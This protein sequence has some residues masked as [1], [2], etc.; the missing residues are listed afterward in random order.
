VVKVHS[1]QRVCNLFIFL[2]FIRNS[3]EK[4]WQEEAMNLD[5]LFFVL[6]LTKTSDMLFGT[7][8]AFSVKS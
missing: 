5:G 4:K 6:D 2:F 1:L 7:W 8:F 3:F